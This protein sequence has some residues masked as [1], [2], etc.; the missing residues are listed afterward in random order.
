MN[1][2]NTTHT[3]H[4]LWRYWRGLGGWNYYFLIKFGLLWFGYLN[5]H[6]LAN[7][8]FMAFLLMPI[9]SLRLHRWRHWLAV[10]IGIA[11][12]YHDT[13]LPGLSSILSQGSQ[14]AGFS[15]DYLLELVTRFINWQMVGAAFVALIG[16]LFLSQWVR[17]TVF[18]VAALVWL[19]LL[20]V[21]GPA[22]SLLPSA[23]STAATPP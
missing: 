18:T 2:K 4:A 9:P 19:N 11:L 20:A 21:G 17:V 7:L 5:F 13:W 22:F 12:F 15:A 16:Y 3:T 1:D 23:P 14:L 8:V 6:P 10:P